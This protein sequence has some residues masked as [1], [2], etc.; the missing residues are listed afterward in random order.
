MVKNPPANT[1]DAGKRCGFN[2]CV[3]RIHWREIWK[4]TPLFLLGESH[5]LK[6]LV[7]YSC[8][9]LDILGN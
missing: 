3:G 2:P 1:G 4:P 7:G 8:K 6:S 5:G 9:G